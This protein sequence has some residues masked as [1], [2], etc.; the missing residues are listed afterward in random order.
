MV[1]K[2]EKLMNSFNQYGFLTFKQ[3][4]DE[5]LHY[6]T[7]LKMVAEGKIVAEEK[8][9]YRLPDIYLDEWFVLQYRFPKGIFSLETALWLHGLSLTI[10]FIPKTLRKQIYVLLFYALTI[11]KELLK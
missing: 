10:P 8:G 4:I 1:D 7:L 2:R 5:N 3:V 6:K 9:L 11:V